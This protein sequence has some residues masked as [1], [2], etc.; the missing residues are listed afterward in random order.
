MKLVKKINCL[1]E[2]EQEK[3]LIHVW[4]EDEEGYIRFEYCHDPTQQVLRMTKRQLTAYTP[5]WE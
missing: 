1:Y 3:E 5:I 4:G 2:N